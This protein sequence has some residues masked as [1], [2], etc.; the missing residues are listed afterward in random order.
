MRVHPRLGAEWEGLHRTSISR[1]WL[2]CLSLQPWMAG[3]VYPLLQLRALRLQEH[4][5]SQ[6]QCPT[7]RNS[8]QDRPTVESEP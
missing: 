4:P 3:S 6:P 8:S 1:T 2:I 5:S 7:K